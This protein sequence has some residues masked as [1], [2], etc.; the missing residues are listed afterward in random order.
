MEN[1]MKEVC[2]LEWIVWLIKWEH[3]WKEIKVYKYI[4]KV[5]NATL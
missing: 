3:F 5:I 1:D 2:E 4:I